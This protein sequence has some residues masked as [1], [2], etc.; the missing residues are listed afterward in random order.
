M[1]ATL[2]TGNG[3]TQNITNGNPGQSFQPDFV[4]VK[5]R[6]AATSHVLQDSV[7]GAGKTLFSNSTSNELG[8]AGDLISSFNS[9]GFTVNDTF[10]GGSGGGGTN[11]TSNSY[12]GWQWKAGGTAVS[13][14]SGTISSQVSAN[15][16]SGFSIVT[17]TG[18]GTSGATIGHGL[19]AVPKM[20]IIKRRSSPVRDWRVYHVSIGNTGSLALN[21]TAATDTNIGY[22]NNTSPT[23][24]V[25]TLG[26]T[27]DVNTSALD[28]VAYCWSEVAGYSKFGSYTGNASSDG[29][30]VYLGFRPKF[31]MFKRTS[32]VGS[33]DMVDTTRSPYNANF[34][35]LLADT[36]GAEV[37]VSTFLDALSNGFKFR[38]TGTD[39]NANGDTYIYAA[40]AEVPFKFANGR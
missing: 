19:S 39:F 10:L 5:N 23:S 12:V 32:G 13:N 22:W 40:F 28:Y 26:N 8:N 7:R 29:P 36:S 33:W 3:T 31:I 1:N 11:G 17:Y 2:Y 6:S 34:P 20:I 27:G 16:T 21:L 18:N 15:T 37:A 14:T 35:L 24:S 25:F 4:W 38:T 9:N 30:F